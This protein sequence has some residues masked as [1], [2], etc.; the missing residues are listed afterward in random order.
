M[1]FNWNYRLVKDIDLTNSKE[2]KINFNI[3]KSNENLEWIFINDTF[4]KGKI[5]DLNIDVEIMFSKFILDKYI[6]KKKHLNHYK[7]NWFLISKILQ[8]IFYLQKNE[9]DILKLKN[10]IYD[11]NFMIINLSKNKLIKFIFEI[12]KISKLVLINNCSI[13]YFFNNSH[14]KGL[15]INQNNKKMLLNKLC[16]LLKVYK[17]DNFLITLFLEIILNDKYFQLENAIKNTLD[18]KSRMIEEFSKVE[19]MEKYKWDSQ[20]FEFSKRSNKTKILLKYENEIDK[21]IE[22]IINLYK[23]NYNDLKIKKIYL[24][25]LYINSFLLKRKT[26]GENA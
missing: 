11:I 17:I 22:K 10:I 16:S 23:S 13:W 2:N 6:V 4:A 8:L 19:N 24:V 5:K 3:L 15:V 7:W 9:A 26:K 12:N 1:F 14:N 21:T 25:L 20:Y 18:N